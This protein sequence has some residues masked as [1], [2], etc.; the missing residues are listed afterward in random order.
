MALITVRGYYRGGQIVLEE[1]P[2][3]VDEAE[4]VVTFLTAPNGQ[5]E[6]ARLKAVQRMLAI[7]ERGFQL[8]G[9]GYTKREELYEERIGRFLQSDD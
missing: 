2:Q 7:M 6:E 3:H 8:G 4:V 1:L 5:D 9:K